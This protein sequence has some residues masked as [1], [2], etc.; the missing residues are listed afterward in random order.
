VIG[1]IAFA[2]AVSGM[3]LAISRSDRVHPF[4]AAPAMILDR[5]S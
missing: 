1:S 3:L 5:T 2:L 4:A